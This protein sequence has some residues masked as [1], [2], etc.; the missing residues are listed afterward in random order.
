MK[1]INSE[2]NIAKKYDLD[3]T[4]EDS[5]FN[6]DTFVSEFSKQGNIAEFEIFKPFFKIDFQCAFEYAIN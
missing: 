5:C 1:I 2:F 3:Y 4:C 6:Y